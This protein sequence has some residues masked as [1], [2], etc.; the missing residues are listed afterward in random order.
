MHQ[1]P[2]GRNHSF[3]DSSILTPKTLHHSLH[4]PPITP[5]TP[6]PLT[7]W[8]PIIPLAGPLS[9]TPVTPYDSPHRPPSLIPQVQS[10]TWQTPSVT[11][12]NPHHS[13][14]QQT[15]HRSPYRPPSTLITHPTDYPFYFPHWPHHS[16]QTLVTHS[17]PLLLSDLGEASSLTL[18]S[19]ITECEIHVTTPP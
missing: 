5:Q 4:R 16:P 12:E 7:H 1:S 10:L 13:P 2:H 6:S 15:P 18:Q 11:S 17:T 19:S 14:R 8:T 3:I 9:L